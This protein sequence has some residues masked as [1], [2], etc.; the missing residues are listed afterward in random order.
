MKDASGDR[1]AMKMAERKLNA[2]GNI[3]SHACFVNSAT[4][5]EKM[6]NQMQLASS[7][8]QVARVQRSEALAKRNEENAEKVTVAPIALAKLEKN[9]GDADK[10]TKKEIVAVLWVKYNIAM[11]ESGNKKQK[12]VDALRD[13]MQ[14]APNDD[15]K[16]S[17]T[18]NN[19]GIEGAI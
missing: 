16:A 15:S 8:S 11:S 2:L 6:R 7:I 14:N 1:A 18:I 4:N 12:L 5:L 9:N 3:N 19:D 13:K 10:L 17:G